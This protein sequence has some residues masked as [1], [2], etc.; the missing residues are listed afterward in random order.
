M[1]LLIDVVCVVKSKCYGR[2]A[3]WLVR[4]TWRC[5]GFPIL[6]V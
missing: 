2:D 5:S 4:W 6:Q 1:Q 3:Y